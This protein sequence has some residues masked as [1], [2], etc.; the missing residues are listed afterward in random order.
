MS[1]LICLRLANF[2]P[3]INRKNKQ[4]ITTFLLI[5][6]VTLVMSVP[7][8]PLRE[9]S[10]LDVNLEVNIPV[11][12][13]RVFSIAADEDTDHDPIESAQNVA[14]ATIRKAE[15]KANKIKAFQD[16]SA[17]RCRASKA[18]L[19]APKTVS[20]SPR[21]ASVRSSYQEALTKVE[22]NTHFIVSRFAL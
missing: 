3:R 4:R 18:K 17:K 13:W 6:S 10:Q 19:S 22:T 5:P 20:S 14:M 9:N 11:P 1:L 2:I 16:L 15:E 21:E 12:H 8:I 7:R